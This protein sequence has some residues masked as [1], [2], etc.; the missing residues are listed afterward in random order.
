MK[1]F[2]EITPNLTLNKTPLHDKFPKEKVDSYT[3]FLGYREM[4][5]PESTQ[6]PEKV[7]YISQSKDQILFLDKKKT[8]KDK[9]YQYN[10]KLEFTPENLERQKQIH[11]HL[12]SMKGV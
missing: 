5:N 4:I 3:F 12:Y 10:E 9:L 7:N 2:P 8:Q 1:L 11:M 6:K